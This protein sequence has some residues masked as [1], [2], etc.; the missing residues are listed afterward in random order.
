M[1]SSNIFTPLGLKPET[2]ALAQLEITLLYILLRNIL[3]LTLRIPMING[4]TRCRHEC[5]HMTLPETSYNLC[6]FLVEM[7][8]FQVEFWMQQIWQKSSAKFTD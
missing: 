1:I 7:S 6:N 4:I 8:P 2:S 5:G 3:A